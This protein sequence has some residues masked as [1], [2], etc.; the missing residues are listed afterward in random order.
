M[1]QTTENCLNPRRM[2]LEKNLEKALEW[3]NNLKVQTIRSKE[4]W[5]ALPPTEKPELR[6][7]GQGDYSDI[8]VRGM[9]L[10]FL[11]RE[12]AVCALC[13]SQ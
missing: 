6:D 11:A 10:F 1:E 3:W 13:T 7:H 12:T 2:S 4:S 9:T 8:N 5:S